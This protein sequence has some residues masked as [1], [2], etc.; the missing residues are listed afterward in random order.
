M[1]NEIGQL[2]SNN[3]EGVSYT[4]NASGLATEVKKNS[5][6]LVKFYYD[7]KVKKESYSSGS[8]AETTHY[9]RDAAGSVMA[10]Y[11]DGAQ[12]ELPIYGSSRLGVYYKNNATVYQLTD[13]LGNV[14]ALVSKQD[15][16][17]TTNWLYRLLPGRDG[18]A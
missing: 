9:V 2:I 6:I 3:E 16:Q 10:I 15:Q 12:K 17:Q 8:L 13:H 11:T 5:Q 7:D 14:R 1:Y 18:D 4:Y